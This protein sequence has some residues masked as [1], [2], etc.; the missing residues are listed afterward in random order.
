MGML[1]K[2]A[3]PFS[4]NR[5]IMRLLL[6]DDYQEPVQDEDELVTCEPVVVELAGDL[7]KAKLELIRLRSKRSPEQF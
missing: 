1:R 2:H 6:G 3:T 7:V 5:T 4:E